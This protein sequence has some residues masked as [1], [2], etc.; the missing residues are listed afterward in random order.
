MVITKPYG[1]WPSPV[2]AASLGKDSGIKYDFLVRFDQ[3]TSIVYWTKCVNE[4]GGRIQ[5]FSQNLEKPSETTAILP[6]GYNCR[7]KVHE[8]GGGAYTVK[9]NT[10]FFSNFDD[11]RVYKIDLSHPTKIIP[12]VP[13]NRLC[14]YADFSVDDELRYIICVHEKHIE[15]GTPEDVVN[16]LVVIDLLEENLDKA[17]KTIAEGNDFYTSPIINP[18]NNELTFI[19]YN[20]PNLP[21]DFTQLYQANL[22]YENGLQVSDLRCIA[23]ES[24]GESIVQPRYAKD[25]SLYVMTD[26]NGYWNLHKYQDGDLQ[27]ALAETI[28][29]DQCGPSWLFGFSDYTPLMND[30]TKILCKSESSLALLDTERRTIVDL[31]TP[32]IDFDQVQVAKVGD[33]DYA[34]F[35]ALSIT[36]PRKFVVYSLS[37]KK[38]VKVLQDSRSPPLDEG[39]ISEPQ[40]IRFPTQHGFGYCYFYPPKNPEFK[41]DGLPPLRVMLHGGPTSRADGEFD[42]NYIYW[43]SR[44]VAIVEVNYGG[45]TGYG[46]EYR[47]LLKKNWGIVDVDDCCAA[48]LY[49]AEMGLVDREKLI[50]TGGSAG[51]F[52]TFACLTFRPEVFKAGCALFPVTDLKLLLLEGHKFECKYLLGLIGEYPEEEQVYYDRSPIHFA[53][54][55]I[56]PAILFHGLDDHAVLPSQSED[57]VRVLNSNK[58][59]NALVTYPGEGHGFRRAENIIRTLELELWF[60]GRILGFPVE[61]IEGVEISNMPEQ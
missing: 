17:V 11:S 15:N 25:G 32:Y 23:G 16:K 45:S 10:L 56:C 19:S 58:V 2:S 60:Y 38:V 36:A 1:S 52:T 24:Q 31:P 3:S 51:G 22:S 35:S 34:L 41:S 28:K 27:Q 8:Y 40:E 42:P 54:N 12:I 57:M 47:N 46:K 13:E 53:Q 21:W 14:R 44:G 7:S 4:E 18:L 9:K 6:I 33:T 37:E 30:A 48:A 49:L 50:I 43:T 20:H 29:K 26:R 59:P 61:G 5:I 55:I 39:Y